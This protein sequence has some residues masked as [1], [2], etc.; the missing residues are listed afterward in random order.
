MTFTFKS[1]AQPPIEKI[2][3][4]KPPDGRGDDDN[5]ANGKGIKEMIF[6]RDKVLGNHIS[7]ERGKEDLLA[8]NKAKVELVQENMLM[9][10]HHVKKSVIAELSVPWKDAPVV[11]QL[12]KSLGYNTMKA[13]LENVWKLTRGFELM[14]VGNSYYWRSG[15]TF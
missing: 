8:T 13:K 7:M 9:P 3:P 10:M 12:G 15:R 5:H 2:I 6:F 4:P 1:S 11:K 14:D